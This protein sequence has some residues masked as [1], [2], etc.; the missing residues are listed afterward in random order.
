MSDQNDFALRGP[1]KGSIGAKDLV[2]EGIDGFPAEGEV[3][4]IGYGLLDKLVLCIF[5]G[6][7][8]S[9]SS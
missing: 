4:I 2:V 9:I 3:E 5:L 6:H 8:G 7:A 1:A